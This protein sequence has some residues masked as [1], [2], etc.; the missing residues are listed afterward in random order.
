MPASFR[1]L[2]GSLLRSAPSNTGVI[3]LKPSFCAAQP[4]W[5]SRIWPTFIR[6]GT[7]SGL[8]RMSTGVPSARN[9]MSSS[10]RTLE[11]TP[12]LPCRPAILSPTEI[13]ALGGAVNLDHLLHA[14]G[15]F[16]AALER[17]QL[18]FAVVEQEQNPF[19]VPCRKL[20]GTASS[21]RGCGCPGRSNLKAA[22]CSAMTLSSLS[23]AKIL[24]VRGSLSSFF[25]S[26]LSIR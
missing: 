9:G 13:C 10:G 21:A 14:A 25:S 23:A 4:R 22:A 8:S 16:V 24:P 5:V 7:P 11:I 15:Q 3:A 12:L 18:A 17:V 2:R 1:A 6:L 26:T 20:L 19:V